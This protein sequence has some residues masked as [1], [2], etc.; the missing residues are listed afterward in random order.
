[1]DLELTN[2]R[3][4][5]TGSSKGIGLVI[6]EHFL[7][8]GA[9]VIISSRDEEKLN[10]AKEKL[11]KEH[12][13]SKIHAFS[14]DFAN[15]DA[16]AQ[17]A[18]NVE[19]S[20]NGIDIVISNVGDGRSGPNALPEPAQWEK[21]WSSNFDTALF[22]ARAFLPLLEKSQGNLLFISSIVAKEA[23]GAPVD[24][25]TAKT[26]VTA[27]AKNMARKL[28]GNVRINVLAPGNIYFEGGSWDQKI[29]ADEARVRNLIQGTVPMN[30]F[31]TPEEIADAALFICS[32][33]AAFMTGSVVVVDG[34]Q[35]VGIF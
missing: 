22:T 32:N 1:V 2:K 35:T 30:R 12:R 5:I 31:G 11:S 18:D 24:Y 6:A 19:S 34:G 9:S 16:V 10:M 8:E 23:F 4:L 26:A 29:K 17:L 14:C 13:A 21:V 3:V 7:K 20:L 28:G 15:S 33:R 25:S 27:L